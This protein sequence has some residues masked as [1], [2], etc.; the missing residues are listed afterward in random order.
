MGKTKGKGEKDMSD[1]IK[2]DCSGSDRLHGVGC[3]VTSCKF[4]GTDN[5]CHADQIQVESHNA[6]RKAET[7]C[8]TFEAKTSM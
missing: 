1:N 2:W 6:I 7:F 8:G 4:H 3:D 5:C